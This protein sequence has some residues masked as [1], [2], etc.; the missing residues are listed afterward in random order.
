MGQEADLA[1]LLLESDVVVDVPESLAGVVVALESLEL[2]SV[3]VVVDEAE[4]APWGSAPR[5]SLR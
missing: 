2:L 3:V 5:L 1:E 4:D